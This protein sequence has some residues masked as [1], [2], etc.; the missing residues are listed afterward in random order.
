MANRNRPA[1]ASRVR[2]S[3]IALALGAS[4]GIAAAEPVRA[5]ASRVYVLDVED[6][7]AK[8]GQPGVLTAR[9]RL[10][11]PYRLL[12][13]YNNRL[14]RFSAYDDGVTFPHEVVRPEDDGGALVFKVPVTPTKPGSHPI[15]GVFRI[16]YIE[17]GDT[18]RMISVPLIARVV[19]T[20]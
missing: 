4:L 7:S 18:M 16:G 15:N 14:G 2:R 20:D 6:A 9:L 17:N 1:G 3:G 19:G 12:E 11:E 13:H 8:V 10:Q 5:E